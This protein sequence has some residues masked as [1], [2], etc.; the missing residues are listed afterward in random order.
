MFSRCVL[1]RH[2]EGQICLFS[3][4]IKLLLE[5]FCAE[6][7]K[8]INLQYMANVYDICKFV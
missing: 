2:G 4:S 5:D 1:S 6:K 3:K 8:V 7:Q